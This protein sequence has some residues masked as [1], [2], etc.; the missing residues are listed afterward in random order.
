MMFAI[1]QRVR[2]VVDGGPGRPVVGSVGTVVST[3]PFVISVRLDGKSEICGFVPE[4][5]A[6]WNGLDVMLE[7]LDEGR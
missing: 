2:V 5:L 1:G 3:G 4:H 6:L 7:V